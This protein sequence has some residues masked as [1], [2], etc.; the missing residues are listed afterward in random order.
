M[1]T[2]QSLLSADEVDGEGYPNVGKVLEK[3]H[4]IKGKS[5]PNIPF[6]EPCDQPIFA[7][8]TISGSLV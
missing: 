6:F 4:L 1:S 3:S 8:E 7:H 2:V 5:R